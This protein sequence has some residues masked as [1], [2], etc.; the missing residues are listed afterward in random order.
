MTRRRQTKLRPADGNAEATREGRYN[1]VFTSQLAELALHH[2][3]QTPLAIREPAPD[4][5]DG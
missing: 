4:N 5:S 3:R 2:F 1:D